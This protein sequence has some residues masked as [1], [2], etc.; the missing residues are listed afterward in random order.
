M[1][2]S[3]TFFFFFFLTFLLFFFLFSVVNVVAFRRLQLIKVRDACGNE[4]VVPL[5]QLLD[6]AVVYAVA[7]P[8]R[9][10]L[11]EVV[12]QFLAAG[13]LVVETHGFTLFQFLD[14]IEHLV[15]GNVLGHCKHGDVA[16]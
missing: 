13:L 6:V 8:F 10:H 3:F 5:Q 11:R 7:V 2:R 15:E 16:Q 9:Q 4:N 14:G 12:L 1:Y